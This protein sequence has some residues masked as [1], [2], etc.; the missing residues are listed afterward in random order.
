[1]DSLFEGRS[2]HY[3][4]DPNDGV[5]IFSVNTAD[6]GICRID[7]PLAQLERFWANTYGFL[8][9]LRIASDHWPKSD[10]SIIEEPR[11][12]VPF[13]LLAWASLGYKQGRRLDWEPALPRPDRP[14]EDSSWFDTVNTFFIYALGF[15]MLHEIGHHVRQHPPPSFDQ[16]NESISYEKDADAWSANWI[17]EN[18]PLDE[19]KRLFRGKCCIL[20]LCAINLVEIHYPL[21]QGKRT[22]P[23]VVE[24]ILEL[25]VSHFPESVGDE[26]VS[27]D[28]PI[29]FSATILHVQ[30]LNMGMDVT[31]GLVHGSTTDYLIDAL[32]SFQ[33]R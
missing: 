23:P 7:A 31:P 24:R 14:G 29:Y 16:D 1:M 5:S 21:Q 10:I 20:A 33:N 15:I 25:L 12:K 30:R 26:V 28:S 3:R 17:F 8:T 6:Q 19:S 27:R 18:C 9:A 22:H 13:A 2:V 4:L 11:L 32:R